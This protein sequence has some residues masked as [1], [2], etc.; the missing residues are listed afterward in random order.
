M[1]VLLDPR[2]AAPALKHRAPQ[3]RKRL[4]TALRLLAEDPSGLA[5]DLDVRRLDVDAGQPMYRLR[6]GDWRIAFT[7]DKDLVVLRV[8]HR[9]EGYGWLADMTL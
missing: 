7:V 2:Q 8:F 9:S 3:P 6:I 1:R 4:R 5:H